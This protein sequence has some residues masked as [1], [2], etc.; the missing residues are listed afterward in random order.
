MA[1]PDI[2]NHQ[3]FLLTIHTNDEKL[4][5]NALPGVHI[6]PL[7]LDSENGV[8]VLRVLFEPGT[9]LPRHFHTGVVHLYTLAGSWHYTEYPDDLQVPGS[10]LFEPGGSIHQFQ[11]PKD[12]TEMTDTFMVVMGSN[13]NFDPDGN[14]MNIMDAGWIEQVMLAA[15]KEQGIEPNYIKPKSL[16]GFNK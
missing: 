16:Y 2:I 10:Y 15:A 6:Y 5:K 11:V 4:I 12:N 1:L 3:D 9:V 8:W 13:I 7:M 14:Y